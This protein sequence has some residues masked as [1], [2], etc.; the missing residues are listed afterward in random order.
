MDVGSLEGDALTRWYLR[1]PGEI[2]Q[3]REDAAAERYQNFFYGPSGTDPDAGV[4]QGAPA[5]DGDVDP[6][7]A[8]SLP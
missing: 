7:L 8:V 4:A 1:S 6:D 5:G 2:D 3:E